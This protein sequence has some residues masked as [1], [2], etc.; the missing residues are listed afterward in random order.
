MQLLR[1][2][3]T[4]SFHVYNMYQVKNMNQFFA[5]KNNAD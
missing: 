4:V 5:Q 1:D 2:N 3:L